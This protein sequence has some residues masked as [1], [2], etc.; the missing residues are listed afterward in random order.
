MVWKVAILVGLFG[1]VMS[2]KQVLEWIAPMS[3]LNALIV[4]YIAFAIFLSLLGYYVFPAHWQAR[5]TLALI[6]VSWALGIVLYLPVSGYSTNITGAHLT[7]V[8]SATEDYVTYQWLQS[9]GINDST[10]IITYAIVP[11]VLILLAGLVVAPNFFSRIL[12]ATM[13]R[14]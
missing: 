8:E 6:L 9:I 12:R 10:G 14:A 4:W 5:Y 1:L 13:G 2:R 7:G 11:A 3:S